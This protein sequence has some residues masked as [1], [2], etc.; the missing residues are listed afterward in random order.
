MNE[1]RKQL[2]ASFS[3]YDN[4]LENADLQYADEASDILFGDQ[5]LL[6]RVEQRLG[7]FQRAPRKNVQADTGRL[8]LVQ[9]KH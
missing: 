8:Q 2:K 1:P 5:L 4:G 3:S 6:H 7:H 9:R